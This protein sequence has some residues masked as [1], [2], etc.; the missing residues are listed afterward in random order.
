LKKAKDFEDLRIPKQFEYLK[1]RLNQIENRYNFTALMTEKQL[2]DHFKEIE[3][4]MKV[5]QKKKIKELEKEY[6][7]DITQGATLSKNEAIRQ[8]NYD[9]HMEL[10][11][12]QAEQMGEM[13]TEQLEIA[14]KQPIRRKI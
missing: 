8:Q 7:K 9:K 10:I 2:E 13:I 1:K 4:K 14:K 12:E 3:T 6:K 5:Q 11:K